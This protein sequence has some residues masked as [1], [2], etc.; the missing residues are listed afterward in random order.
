MMQ[1]K[2][3]LSMEVF[4]LRLNRNGIRVN[5]ALEEPARVLSTGTMQL[6]RRGQAG[7]DVGAD[8]LKFVSC[9]VGHTRGSG[10]KGPLKRFESLPSLAIILI[11]EP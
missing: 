8:R 11:L 2:R 3:H 10:R 1:L 5:D 7:C 6:F 4:T 9:R